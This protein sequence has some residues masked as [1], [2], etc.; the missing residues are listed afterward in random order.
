MYARR[1]RWCE[2]STVCDKSSFRSSSLRDRGEIGSTPWAISV[3]GSAASVT[4]FAL[5]SPDIQLHRTAGMEPGQ[6]CLTIIMDSN[7]LILASIWKRNAKHGLKWS[8][9][10]PRHFLG[11]RREREP[12]ETRSL[13]MS[14]YRCPVAVLVIG[15]PTRPHTALH[16]VWR[17]RFPRRRSPN[18][19]GS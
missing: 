15:E 11:L 6:Y 7:G 17:D 9:P 1:I 2:G 10:V 8:T 18:G 4:R 16:P 19:L 3:A 5:R 14:H 12:K 13:F